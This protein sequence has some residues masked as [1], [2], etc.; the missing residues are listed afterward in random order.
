M[1][2]GEDIVTIAS[3]ALRGEEARRV[4][5]Q[6]VHGVESLEE[7]QMHPIL[8]RGLEGEGLGVLREQPYPGEWQTRRGRRKVLPEQSERKRCDLV[9][10]PTPGQVLADRLLEARSQETV[11]R[12]ASGTLFAEDAQRRVAE[13]LIE[14]LP[15]RGRKGAGRGA[16]RAASRTTVPG[17]SS[18]PGAVGE[19]EVLVDVA[20]GE[21]LA[22]GASRVEAGDTYWLEVKVVGQFVYSAGVPGPNAQYASELVRGARAD[23]KKLRADPAIARGGLLLVHLTRD[24]MTAVHDELTLWHR[25]LD[26]GVSVRSPIAERFAIADRIGNGLCSVVLLEPTVGE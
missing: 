19:V 16:A 10:T 9:L 13:G 14:E 21:V 2:R 26:R 7:V 15:R 25:L 3:A 5:E 18:T 24:E 8:A 17:A 1:W 6:A 20:T 22:P 11:L 4:V 12:E 23:L